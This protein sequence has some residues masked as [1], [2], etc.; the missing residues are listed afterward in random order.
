MRSMVLRRLAAMQERAARQPANAR[1]V[2]ALAALVAMAGRAQAQAIIGGGG[3]GG[4]LTS[5]ITWVMSNIMVGLVMAAVLFIGVLIMAGRAGLLIICGVAVG[6]LIIGNYQ[7]IA[8]TLT[9]GF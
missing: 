1:L 8:T 4:L 3:G 2:L 6:A 7:T 5:V 9:S